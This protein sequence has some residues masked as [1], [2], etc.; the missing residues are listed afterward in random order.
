MYPHLNDV[1]TTTM[2]IEKA[3]KCPNLLTYFAVVNCS[4]DLNFL[5]KDCKIKEIREN[6]KKKPNLPTFHSGNSKIQTLL[7]M[8]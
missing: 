6:P 2:Q 8:H 7:E 4:A 5:H 1:I 3:T